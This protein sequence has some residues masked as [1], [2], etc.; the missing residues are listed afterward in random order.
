M[1]LWFRK[2]QQAPQQGAKLE[3]SEVW[4]WDV[5]LFNIWLS[6]CDVTVLA[7]YVWFICFLVLLVVPV[8]W[9]ESECSLYV[10]SYIWEC[11][12]P[13]LISSVRRRPLA[14]GP[15]LSASPLNCWIPSAQLAGLVLSSELCC[16][17]VCWISL[18]V[19]K[20]KHRW[21]QPSFSDKQS[22][23]SIKNV[24]IFYWIFVS[25]LT[26]IHIFKL[27]D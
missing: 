13:C 10:W 24:L 23:L 11:R 8:F 4:C 17:C 20:M 2:I 12:S 15:K 9:F 14:M 21:W 3:G 7:V 19:L 1:P 5:F 18:I 26:V 27:F 6:Y 22:V 16:V 25:T